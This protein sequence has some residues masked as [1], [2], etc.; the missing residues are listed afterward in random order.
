MRRWVGSV[1]VMRGHDAAV[2]Y[3]HGGFRCERERES[4]ELTG[5]FAED[6]IGVMITR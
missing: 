2:L 4:S 1:G 3:P 5:V 6:V